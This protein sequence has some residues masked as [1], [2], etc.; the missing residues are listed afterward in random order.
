[1]S[2]SARSI[3]NPSTDR[4]RGDR[5]LLRELIQVAGRPAAAAVASLSDR[6]LSR[7][8]LEQYGGTVIKTSLSDADTKEL[9]DALQK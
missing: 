5:A 7:P 1:L 8:A 6:Q 9:Q 2:A 4:S 3:P